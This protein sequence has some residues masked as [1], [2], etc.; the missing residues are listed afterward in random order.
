MQTITVAMASGTVPYSVR[1]SFKPATAPMRA[2]TPSERRRSLT[3]N[4]RTIPP[5][6]CA[7]P[8]T[9]PNSSGRRAT[10]WS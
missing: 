9:A 7:S 10:A 2:P 3:W 6:G 1:R 5:K 8:S 4:P